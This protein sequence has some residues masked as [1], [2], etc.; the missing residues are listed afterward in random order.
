MEINEKKTLSKINNK[1]A[2][3][4]FVRKKLFKPTYI[5]KTSKFTGYQT[6]HLVKTNG[7]ESFEL[8]MK[9]HE[10]QATLVLVQKDKYYILGENDCQINLNLDLEPGWFR[11]RLIGQQAKLNFTLSRHSK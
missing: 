5:G 7:Y 1:K 8:D 4:F 9:I 10:G 6:F 3:V 11:L 2:L